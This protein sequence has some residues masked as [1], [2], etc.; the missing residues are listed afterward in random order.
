[1]GGG[2]VRICSGTCCTKRTI[3][4]ESGAEILMATKSV[5]NIIYSKRER[6]IFIVR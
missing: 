2:K 5:G 4:K 3:R 6:K 1:V